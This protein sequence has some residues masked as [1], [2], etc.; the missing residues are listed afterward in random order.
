MRFYIDLSTLSPEDKTTE[1]RLSVCAYGFDQ[2]FW[3]GVIVV[4]L[5]Q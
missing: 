1:Q 4:I 5:G 2:D 3:M